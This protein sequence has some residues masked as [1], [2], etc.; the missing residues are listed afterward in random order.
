MTQIINGEYFSTYSEWLLR[1]ALEASFRPT[2]VVGIFA[3][4]VVGI[5]RSPLMYESEL[6]VYDEFSSKEL[7]EYWKEI[8]GLPYPDRVKAI[9]Q[10]HYRHFVEQGNQI[11]QQ[12]KSELAMNL[13]P[14]AMIVFSQPEPSSQESAYL[15]APTIIPPSAVYR[16]M[17][18]QARQNLRV[19]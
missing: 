5:N 4:P 12:A 6:A 9:E 15:V 19:H 17:L 14:S 1:G 7:L 16:F 18:D 3:M 11:L 8:V 10:M 13:M 2:A